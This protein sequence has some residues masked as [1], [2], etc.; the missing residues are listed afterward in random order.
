MSR[1]A[2]F[3]EVDVDK[4]FTL[5]HKLFSRHYVLIEVVIEADRNQSYGNCGLARA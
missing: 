2:L 1:Q 4:A 5:A 3:Q